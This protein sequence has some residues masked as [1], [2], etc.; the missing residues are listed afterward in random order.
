MAFRE[1]VGC[2]IN[3]REHLK[4]CLGVLGPEPLKGF[5]FPGNSSLGPYTESESVNHSME[6]DS[7]VTPWTVAHQASLSMGFSRQEYWSECPFPTLGDLADLGIKLTSPTSPAL[8]EQI[9]YH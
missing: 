3:S 8:A 7:F 6:S 1:L 4:R 5:I 2:H 9:L